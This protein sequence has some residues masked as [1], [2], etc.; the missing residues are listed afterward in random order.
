METD[1]LIAKE[2]IGSMGSHRYPLL[3]IRDGLATLLHLVT[4]ITPEDILRPDSEV[5][6]TETLNEPITSICYIRKPMQ[7]TSQ[8]SS[9]FECINTKGFTRALYASRMA[10]HFFW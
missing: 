4:N 9:V 7:P 2:F 3:R 8:Q 1:V 6:A 10:Y 5:Q